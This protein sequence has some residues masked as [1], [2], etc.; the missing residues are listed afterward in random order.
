M[1]NTT[2]TSMGP[3]CDVWNTALPGIPS[4][5]PLPPPE[6]TLSLQMFLPWAFFSTSLKFPFQN[7]DLRS[8][9]SLFP[10]TP[11]LLYL[12]PSWGPGG[13]WTRG[14]LQGD[15]QGR[16][17]ASWFWSTPPRPGSAVSPPCWGLKPLP[18]DTGDTAGPLGKA[19]RRTAPSP[20]KCQLLLPLCSLG[21]G[22]GPF[23]KELPHL[24]V[25]G[26]VCPA[27]SAGRTA[28]PLGKQCRAPSPE[29]KSKRGGFLH[30]LF[31]NPGRE[32]NQR[33]GNS[34]LGRGGPPC[35]EPTVPP[36]PAARAA[37]SGKGNRKGR[38][39]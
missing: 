13:T 19:V 1:H 34:S 38:A 8:E 23:L 28:Q 5:C 2:M 29:Y 15:L 27:T 4:G 11:R 14:T 3:S 12:Q 16:V 36:D 30:K 10:R 17:A 24:A 37:P 25:G 26:R 6:V 9:S 31:S 21:E 39:G 18:R 7:G 33:R 32:N 35:G 22:L 20:R